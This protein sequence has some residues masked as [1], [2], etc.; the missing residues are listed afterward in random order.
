MCVFLSSS[1]M[2]KRTQKS[3]ASLDLINR[4]LYFIVICYSFCVSC[5]TDMTIAEEDWPEMF[6]FL[7][8]T[9]E[10]WPLVFSQT[11]TSTAGT[12]KPE[13]RRTPSVTWRRKMS[14]SERGTGFATRWW[15]S[16]SRSESW[17][18][19]R[20]QWPVRQDAQKH[21]DWLVLLMHRLNQEQQEKSLGF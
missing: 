7:P 15:L 14:W 9:P 12:G 6:C 21:S 4:K 1:D 16:G 13:Q 20:R 2:G 10:I 8:M 3:R 18:T 5:S 11:P 17:R 19:S